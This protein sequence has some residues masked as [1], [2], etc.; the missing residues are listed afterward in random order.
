[1]R[2]CVLQTVLDPFKG[3]NHLPL[4]SAVPEVQFTII[5]N[6]SKAHVDELPANVHVLTVPGRI[7][8][9]YYGCADFRF[10]QLLLKQYPPA[11]D[12]W[13][14]F[15]IIHC[16]Q[17]MGPALRKLRGCGV[18]LLFL[19]HHPVTV[20]RGIA[21]AESCG[22]SALQWRAKYAL[23]VRWQKQMCSV[24]DHIAT[25]SQTAKNRII[26]DYGC[27][28]E[29]VSIVPNGVD[30]KVFIPGDLSVTDFEVIAVGSFIHPRKGFSYLL[31]AY[32]ALADRGY[33]IADV[34]RRSDAQRDA[35]ATIPQ[36]TQF[37]TVQHE[38]LVSLIQRSAT[39]ISTSLYE[40]FGLSLIEALACGRPAFAFDGGAVR[41]V[42]K[43]I[44]ENLVAP[45]RDASEIVD[46]VGSFLD[47]P[48][49]T[50]IKR[51]KD[52]RDAVLEQ[53]SL[54]HSGRALSVLYNSLC[55]DQN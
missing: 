2:V 28:R 16:N 24:V 30:G 5:C 47:L 46:R 25:V 51:G 36:V 9:Y 37:G 18:P 23:L 10:A 35:L 19:I 49:A 50:R 17:I 8:P 31:E 39:L 55:Q 54:Q 45:L 40:G 6:R 42:L 27:H 1:M 32:R 34:G 13:K 15:N 52:Y 41:E 53:Y 11:S 26:S 21:L 44:D 33:R 7:G 29:K 4:L 14:Q 3:G 38:E 22:L 43:P 48:E 12:F 20:D